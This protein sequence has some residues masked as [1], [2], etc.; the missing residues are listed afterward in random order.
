[1]KRK[2]NALLDSAI[3]IAIIFSLVI[4]VYVLKVSVIAPFNADIQASDD[5]GPAAK[6]IISDANTNYASQFDFVIPMVF[7]IMWIASALLGRDLDSNAAYFAVTVIVMFVVVIIGM[8]L[9]MSYEDIIEDPDY[10]GIEL[11]FP[12]THWLMTHIV[13]MIVLVIISVAVA[14]YSK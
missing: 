2:G 11:T 14:I 1:M 6:G 13:P 12:K 7:I 5:Y 9:E 3:I 4:V 8:S 10:V